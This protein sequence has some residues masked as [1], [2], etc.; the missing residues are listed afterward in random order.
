MSQSEQLDR[1]ARRINWLDRYRRALSILVAA[2]GGALCIWWLT[3]WLPSNWPSAHMV[4]L[5]VA[6]VTF[7]W[8]TIET[9]LGFVLAL[10]ETNYSKLTK[11]PGLPRA[12]V[13]RRK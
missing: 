6:I 1:L 5:A 10:W 3:G 8:Y 13:I 2:I 7:G 4:M 9:A 12:E 11:P